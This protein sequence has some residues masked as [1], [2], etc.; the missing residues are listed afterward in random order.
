[1]TREQLLKEIKTRLSKA[2]G[3]RLL[4][5]V[6]YGSEARGTA[7]PDS[8]IDVLVLL[9]GP[10]NYGPDLET[11]IK[12]LYPLSLQIERPISP[13]PIDASEYESVE[14]PLYQNAHREGILL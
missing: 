8:D 12:T 10:V 14:C 6:L 2:H 4:G 9:E 5:V 11:N 7:G 13:K 3:K 1:M